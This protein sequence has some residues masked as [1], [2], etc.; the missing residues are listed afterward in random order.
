VRRLIVTLLLFGVAVT[1]PPASAATPDEVADALDGGVYVA[2]DAETVD[3]GRLRDLVTEAAADGLE[4]RVVVLGA[5]DGG[6]DSIAFAEAVAERAGGTVLVFSPTEY[7]VS[8]VE[9]SQPDLGDALD[10]AAGALGGPDIADGV[11]AFIDATRPRAFNWPL[12]IGGTV[13]VLVVVGV[14]GRV[15][16]S[17]ATTR[18]RTRALDRKWRELG[19]RADALADPILELETK[20]DLA[21][22]EDVATRYGSAANH[23]GEL[24]RR[25]DGPPEAAAVDDLDARL[26]ALEMTFA[27]IR[28][29]VDAS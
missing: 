10:E 15:V 9:L 5:A 25:L 28:R 12:L 17:R 19:A 14:A 4:V 7:G 6:G 27:E 8:S 29:T 13:L 26:S 3:A 16:E 22:R 21:G 2:S 18:R 23:F 20:V 11:A 24:R 1:A